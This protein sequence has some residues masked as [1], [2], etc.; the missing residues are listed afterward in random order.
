ME[1]IVVNVAWPYANG[2]IHVGHVAGSLL[3]PDI[4]ARYHRMK[5]NR[6]LMVSGSDQHG[7]PV[8]LVAEKEKKTPE[9]IAE[10]YHAI[11]KDSIEWLGLSFDIY[12]KT[13]TE[14][15][16][17]VVQDFFRRLD[18]KGY[19]Y[20]KKTNQYFCVRDDRFLADTYVQGRCPKCGYEEAKGNQ[21]EICGTTFEP[22]ELLNAKC[23]LC[24]NPTILRE[25][26]NVFF[27]LS[28]FSDALMK[29]LSDKEFW[30]PSVLE[31]SKNWIISGL[32]DRAV[33]RDIDWG[34]PPPISNL[35][36]KVIYVWFEAVIGYLS[37]SIEWAKNSGR[38][39]E[40]KE[41]WKD[42]AHHYYFMGKDNIPF[43]T[44]IWPAML[45]GH[46][47][48]ALPYQ[49]VA[50]QY[51]TSSDT[52]KFSKSR[53]G[54]V[55]VL[56]L[57]ESFQP[58]HIRYYLT[59]I[60]PELHDS[61]FSFEDMEQKVNNELVA[62]LG[63]YY[64]RVLSFSFKNFGSINMDR[65]IDDEMLKEADRAA[66]EVGRYIEGC[67][68]KKGLKTIM[69]LAQKG[70]QYFDRCAPWHTV[71]T[72]REKCARDLYV[73][74][75]VIRKIA[76]MSYPYL[77]F[78]SEQILRF[79]GVWEDGYAV[80]A[81]IKERRAG[82]TLH[83]PK[84][85]FSKLV[86]SKETL[87]LDLRVGRIISASRHPAADRLLVLEVD[88]GEKRQIVA[89]LS[90]YYR[91]EELVGKKVIVVAN[92]QP[93]K[94]RG[95]E[96]DGMLLAAEKDGRVK[97][98]TVDDDIP[99]GPLDGFTP[100]KERISLDEFRRFDLRIAVERDGELLLEENEVGQEVAVLFEGDVPRKLT[101]SGRPV[102]SDGRIGAGAKI[103]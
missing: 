5:G 9:E 67:E 71:K 84:P 25:T 74:L 95:L 77:P 29:Y 72:D 21:C 27:A 47:E 100:G 32:N 34:I 44:I 51:L 41:F 13:H 89:G 20:L 43:H 50:N 18:E 63:N 2:P 99:S 4:F 66:E 78:S 75:E 96:S 82:Y 39:D 3:A 36:G 24:G 73:N 7:T 70:N 83:E 59:A 6:V 15:H 88:I 101:A 37:A 33:T 45:M 26:E 55:T 80:W 60:M 31:F 94:L 86:I 62:T 42:D 91:E 8:T 65:E 10:K 54:A 53:G 58:E 87:P 68:F 93:A 1:K 22:G 90:E 79:L 48:L 35:N 14:N 30:R 46:G 23:I 64:H 19:F 49:V 11:N 56:S 40:W 81:H 85:V 57:K 52:R 28:K 103:R 102:R 38:P 17:R 98:L 76:L 61:E 92:L 69:E 16:F 97:L 12:T